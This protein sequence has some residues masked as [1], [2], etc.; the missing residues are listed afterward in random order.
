MS[1]QGR[2][3]LFFART[4]QQKGA[5]TLACRKP[6]EKLILSCLGLAEVKYDMSSNHDT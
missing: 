4:E 6:D 5:R 2:N 3:Y 1:F